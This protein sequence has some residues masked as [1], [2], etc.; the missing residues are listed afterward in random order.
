[1]SLYPK[2]EYPGAKSE[3]K[4]GDY[5]SMSGSTCIIDNKHPGRRHWG[6]DPAG[7]YREWGQTTKEN[8]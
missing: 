7:N 6:P 8:K 5:H 2:G 1:M 3:F 4:C